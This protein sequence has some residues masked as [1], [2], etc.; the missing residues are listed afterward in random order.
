MV[1]CFHVP[2]EAHADGS[3]PLLSPAV[4]PTLDRNRKN[5]AAAGFVTWWR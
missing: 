3:L 1:A 4:G 2:G 5:P